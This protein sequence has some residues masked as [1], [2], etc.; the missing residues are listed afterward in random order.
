MLQRFL[1]LAGPA[2]LPQRLAQL[3]MGVT[4][5]GLELHGSPEV[6][7][8]FLE[9]VLLPDGNREVVFRDGI[10]VAAVRICR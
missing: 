10:T 8:C 2:E 9:P 7:D 4:K 5:I 6:P 1:G 3:Q